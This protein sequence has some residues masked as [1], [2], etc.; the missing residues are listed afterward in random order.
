MDVWVFS[1][2]RGRFLQNCIHSIT[3]CLS[4]VTPNILDDHSNDA[5]TQATLAALAEYCLV[6]TPQSNGSGGKHGGL[7]ANMQQALEKTT[8][9]LVLLL[10]DDTQLVRAIDSAELAKIHQVFREQPRLAFIQ[11]AFLRGC[12]AAKDSA[13]TRYVAALNGYHVD[14]FANS[15]GAFYSDIVIAHASRLKAAN[16]CFGPREP[17]NEQR[18]RAHFAQM[19]YWRDPF[20][21]WLPNVPAYRGKRQTWAMRVAH[22]QQGAGFYPLGILDTAQVAALKARADSQLPYAEDFLQPVAPNI[23]APWHYY[24]LQ[25]RRL[26]KILDRLERKIS[27][28]RTANSTQKRQ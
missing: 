18:A 3:A 2:N 8:S 25:G 11:P 26:L 14:R 15:A 1:Y 28:S 4:S 24:P 6:H 12:N 9:E 13:A 21:A 20:V 10:Q 23:A 7:Y 16:W 5:D 27:T 17:A 19:V 22:R